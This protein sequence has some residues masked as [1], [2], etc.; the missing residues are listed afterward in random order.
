MAE[1]IALVKMV[2]DVPLV[3]I[4][5]TDMLVKTCEIELDTA[6][7]TTQ[8]DGYIASNEPTKDYNFDRTT[9]QRSLKL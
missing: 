5:P 3:F 1:Q 2:T 9:G 7:F 4:K 8:E 6:G